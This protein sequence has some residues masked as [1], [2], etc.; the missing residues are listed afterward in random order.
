MPNNPAGW[1]IAHFPRADLRFRSH[2]EPIS[3]CKLC[4]PQLY[5]CLERRTQDYADSSLETDPG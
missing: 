5:S 1:H 4:R 3:L 2:T